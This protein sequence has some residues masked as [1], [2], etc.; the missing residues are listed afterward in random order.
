MRSDRETRRDEKATE[1]ERV[2][3]VR[4][5][6]RRR[7]TIVFHDV[8]GS[9]RPHAEAYERDDCANDQG[10]WGR[11]RAE[12]DVQRGED[13]AERQTESSRDL[14][15]RQSAISRS[16]LRAMTRR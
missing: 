9:P 6:S 5:W 12:D 2:P 4:V 3:R 1:V 7:Q 10:K 8:A 11:S 15:V 13:E 14:L 16:K